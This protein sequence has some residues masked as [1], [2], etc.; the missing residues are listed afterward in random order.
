MTSEKHPG[1]PREGKKDERVVTS[2]EMTREEARIA[3][4]FLN[5]RKDQHWPATPMQRRMQ[6]AGR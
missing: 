2:G 6:G 4:R 3:E 1:P 5:A